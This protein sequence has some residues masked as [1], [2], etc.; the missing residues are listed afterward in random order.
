MVLLALANW[1]DEGGCAYPSTAAIAEFGDM[2]HKTATVA[3]DRLIA[4]NLVSDTGERE[5]R[6]KQIKVY[7]LN[8]ESLPQTEAFQKR[9]PSVSSP[10]APQK[11]GTDTIRKQASTDAT[12]PPKQRASKS[13]SIH[14]R[15]PDDWRPIRFA[16]GTVAREVVDRR[17]I[18]WA[19][20]A[21]ESFRNWAV[22]ADDKPGIGR[23]LNWQAAWA[24]WTIEQDR[25]DGR[26]S[27]PANDG[28]G[29]GPSARAAIAVFGAPN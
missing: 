16:D 6:T 24:N 19:R 4:L 3:L 29:L 15:L 1:A 28:S 21:L 27:R 5:G 20:A 25:R 12:H 13:S 9:K 8:L 26:Q 23:K 18:E 14:I 10:K 7:K 17:G 22:N 2:D 11:R